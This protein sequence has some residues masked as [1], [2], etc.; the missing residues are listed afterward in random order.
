MATIASV[1]T[2][3]NSPFAQIVAVPLAGIENHRQVLLLGLPDKNVVMEEI[4][5]TVKADEKAEQN[6]INKIV[7]KK[8]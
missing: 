6:K 1:K 2:S 4:K 8:P 5:R 7:E 3:P